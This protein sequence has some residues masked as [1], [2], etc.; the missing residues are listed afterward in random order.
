MNHVMFDLETLGLT[1]GSIILSIGAVFF[2]PETG[3][4][5]P[6]FYANIDRASCEAAGLTADPKTEAW[7]R[8]QSPEARERLYE[9]QRPLGQV[10]DEFREWL[11]KDCDRLWA[12]DPN[13]DE[14]VLAAAYRAFGVDAPWHYRS[15]R[16]CRTIYDLAGVAA[17]RD[18][19]V[20]H[21]A[22]VDSKNQAVAVHDA[23]VKLGLTAPRPFCYAEAADHG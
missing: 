13:M 4:M 2:D 1:P 16:S 10:L 22:L 18:V 15:P 5:G 7:W 17:N 21:D 3:K 8:E 23:Y 9:N 20:H 12:N 6:E 19:G 11:G 14:V